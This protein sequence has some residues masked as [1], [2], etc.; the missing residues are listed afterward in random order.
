MAEFT[1]NFTLNQIE[2]I[3]S[4][5]TLNESTELEAVFVMHPAPS[6]ISELTN[7]ADYVQD[8]D[9]VH[10]DNN[11]TDIY[12]SSLD[13]QSGTNT[14]DITV[15]DSSEIDLTLT[16]Q[17][18]TASIKSASIDKTKL[19]TSVN[20]SLDLADSALQSFTEADPVFSASPAF[21]V[22]DSGDG[23]QYLSDDG[24]YKVVEGGVTS[25][26]GEVGDVTLAIPDQL[27]D[28]TD[29]STHRLV[30]DTE[31]SDWYAKQ[32]AGNYATNTALTN[33]LALKV[34]KIIGKGLS[35]E[36]Y[37]P[38][39]KSKLA[40]IETGA[41]NY[42]LPTDVVQDNDYVHTDNNF[43]DNLLAN[44]NNQSGTNTGDQDLSTYAKIIQVE[45]AKL[46]AIAMAVAL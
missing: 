37:T 31:K 34:D 22:I 3:E 35:T 6:K 18:L 10:T 19:D 27:S 40:G 42:I 4:T 1:A 8:A 32:P 11:F 30:T 16:G 36:D 38:T 13:N 43:T 25:V 26:N 7:D 33:G 20:A 41:N 23:T 12:K 5:F 15:T 2:A 17:S 28:L 29:D 9:Y 46:F 39:E 21:N 44:L 45:Q 24:T 14:G